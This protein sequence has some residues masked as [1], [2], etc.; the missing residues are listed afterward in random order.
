MSVKT[1]NIVVSR[2]FDNNEQELE[3]YLPCDLDEDI[4]A[5]CPMGTQCLNSQVCVQEDGQHALGGCTNS[6]WGLDD[7]GACPCQPSM[8]E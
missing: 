1:P 8:Y 4:S 7:G 6:Q 2:C 3:D 5:C